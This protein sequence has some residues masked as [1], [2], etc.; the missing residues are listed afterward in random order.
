MINIPVDPA[1]EFENIGEELPYDESLVQGWANDKALV[2]QTKIKAL[3]A[4]IDFDQA[5]DIEF[6]VPL[7]I[8][9][10]TELAT[11]IT[12][13]AIQVPGVFQLLMEASLDAPTLFNGIKPDIISAEIGI[14][15]VTHVPEVFLTF[16]F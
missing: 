5:A 2:T 1:D 6:G 11:S 16:H 14:N 8:P 4:Q 13:M 10:W 12:E 15:S 7:D 3:A 9:A